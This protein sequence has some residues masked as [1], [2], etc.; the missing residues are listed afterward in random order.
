[1]EIS[2]T[3]QNLDP[4]LFEFVS[5]RV[6]ESEEIQGESLGYWKDSLRRLFQNKIATTSLIIVFLVYLLSIIITFTTPHS[7]VI[8]PQI[9]DPKT[10]EIIRKQRLTNLPPRVKGL[11]WLGLD[12]KIEKVVPR[13]SLDNAFY[14]KP[15]SYEIKQCEIDQTGQDMC[16]VL[17]DVYE[18]HDIKSLYFPFG[19]DNGARDMWTRVWSGIRNSLSI[20]LLTALFDLVLGVLYGSIAGFF[21]GTKLDNIMMRFI[22]IYGSI[23]SIVLLILLLSFMERGFGA[24]IVAMG[25]TGWIGVARMVRAQFLRYRDHDFVLASRTIGAKNSRLIFKHIFPNIIGQIVILATFSIPSAIFY[26]ASLSFIGLGLPIELSSLG[27]LINS[28]INLRSTSP[29]LLW[30]PTI[31]LAIIMLAINL[32]ANGLRDALDPKLRGR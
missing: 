9:E 4:Q 12:G 22:E 8:E 14:F 21:G 29:Y 13:A 7:N 10:G 3:N 28:G 11:E 16:T 6:D 23:P 25:L 30:I 17:H 1:M 27:T 2:N 15:G 24:L 5:S 19:T 26:E 32:L 18:Q 20:A 31:V